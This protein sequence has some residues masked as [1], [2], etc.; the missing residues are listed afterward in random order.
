MSDI[1]QY[2]NKFGYTRQILVVVPN[3]K[4]SEILFRERPADTCGQTK[5]WKQ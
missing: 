3:L 1:L 4:L 5:G 2:L